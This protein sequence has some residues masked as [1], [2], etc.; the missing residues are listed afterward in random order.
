M[1][2]L[3]ANLVKLDLATDH[4]ASRSH[5]S[6]S[7]AQ[8]V[9]DLAFRGI[10]IQGLSSFEEFLRER[11]VEWVAALTAARLS[12]ERLPGGAAI[13]SDQIVKQLPKYFY[14][15][16]SSDRSVVA[17]EIGRT[18]ETLTKGTFVAHEVMFAWPG[19]N[20]Q[21]SDIESMVSQLGVKSGLASVNNIW[22]LVVGGRPSGSTVANLIDS[23]AKPR[24]S[25]AHNVLAAPDP[26]AVRGVTRSV[27][28]ASLLID[29]CISLAVVRI[30]EGGATG[31]GQLKNLADGV[32]LRK[33]DR[34]GIKWAERAPGVSRAFKRHDTL[35]NA[36]LAAAGRAR[37]KKEILVAYEG[38]E[39]VNW[40]AFI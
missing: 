17:S 30:Q 21:T 18:F 29:S 24:H 5:P 6:D 9:D 10:L 27:R 36:M 7:A 20:V 32:R 26:I 11:R 22:D 25:A 8:I 35:E 16:A 3:L 38:G 33:I 4:I 37:P 39:V 1:D 13:V 34:D 19:S 12:P 15:S 28:I 31:G 23:F 40:S 2:N 14:N